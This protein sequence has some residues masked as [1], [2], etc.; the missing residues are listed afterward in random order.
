M[1][2]SEPYPSFYAQLKRF[3]PAVLSAGLIYGGLHQIIGVLRYFVTDAIL[4]FMNALIRKAFPD[5]FP[6][7]DRYGAPWGWGAFQVYQIKMAALGVIVVIVGI[8]AGIWVRARALRR[9]AM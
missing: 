3:F 2:Q 9:I 4:Q 8:L 1:S 6:L 7:P 5:T